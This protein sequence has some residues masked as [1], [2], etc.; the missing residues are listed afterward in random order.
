MA[1][2][3]LKIKKR[4]GPVLILATR[5]HTIDGVGKNLHFELPYIWPKTCIGFKG[6]QSNERSLNTLK[7]KELQRDTS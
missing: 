2:G 3:H 1:S 7:N 4:T 5:H 6:Y